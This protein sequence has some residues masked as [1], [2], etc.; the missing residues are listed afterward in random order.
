M[1]SPIPFAEPERPV[2]A[3]RARMPPSPRLSAR[4]TIEMYLNET[5]KLSDQK[6]SDSTPR[7]LS[8]VTATPCGPEKH[9]SKAYSGLVPMSP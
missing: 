3:S 6:I 2:S 1:M 9:S 5:T 7:T 8:C 4:R